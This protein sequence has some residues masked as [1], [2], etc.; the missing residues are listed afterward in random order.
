MTVLLQVMFWFFKTTFN[1]FSAK[2][3]RLKWLQQKA[4]ELQQKG[5]MREIFILDLDESQGEFLEKYVREKMKK[6]VQ[7]PQKE[8]NQ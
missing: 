4:D 7:N 5:R 8:G 3:D 6:K 1:W 2:D